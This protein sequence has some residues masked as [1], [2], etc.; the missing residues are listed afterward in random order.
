MSFRDDYFK[1]LEGKTPAADVLQFSFGTVPNQQQ[2]YVMVMPE[3]SDFGTMMETRKNSWGI[4]YALDVYNTGLLPRPGYF[5]LPDVTKWKEVVKAPYR[6]DYDFKAAAE[7]DLAVQKWDPETQVAGTFG[8]GGDY[9]LRLSG[10]MG[11]EGLMFAMYDEP[12]AM[13]ELLDYFCDYDCWLV[14]NV[15]GYY[16]VDIAGFGDDNATEINPFISYEMFKEFLFPRYKR[17]FD[18]AKN[19]GK[20]ISYHNCGRC[21]DFMDDMV[22]IGAQIWNCATPVNDLMGFKE[23]YDF[24]IILEVSPR[25]YPA[26]PEDKIRSEVRRIIDAYAPGGA[27]VWIGAS[28]A[29]GPQGELVNS[30]IRDEVTKYGKDFYL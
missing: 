3:I 24:K 7:R 13:N 28:L 15:L 30:W 26:D 6:Y 22:D 4:E 29:T 16:P 27:F 2:G 25:L 17:V 1:M 12:E 19:H 11:F 18:V 5:M 9:F 10:F 14:D 20:I 8:L 21:E 23:K